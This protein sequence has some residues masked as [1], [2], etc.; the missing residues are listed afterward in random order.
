[1]KHISFRIASIWL[2]ISVGALASI[3]FGLVYIVVLHEPGSAFYLFAGLTFLGGSLI[4]GIVAAL[5]TQSHRRTAFFLSCGAVFGIAGMLCVCTY[6]A[7]P[8]FARTNVQLPSFCDGFDGSLDLPSHLTYTLPDNG[9]GILITGDAQSAVVAMIDSN[10]PPF[11]TTVFLVNKSDNR[12]I[13]SMRFSNDIVS[14]AIDE[15][16]A[17][18]YNDKLGYFIDART[19]EFAKN[20]L[21]IDNYGG[22]AETDRP[23]ISRAS[24][25]HWYMET[26]AVISSW[27]VDGTVKSRPHLTFNG[28]AMGCFISGETHD[29]TEL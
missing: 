1:M 6:V 20:F 12:I 8:Q 13:W 15:G 10:N 27:N 24:S 18:I 9:T 14:A 11:P 3:V 16:V 17:Y 23:I 26:T 28:I 19:G 21:S 29:V 4:G 7:L 5:K 2:G 22:L 25:G